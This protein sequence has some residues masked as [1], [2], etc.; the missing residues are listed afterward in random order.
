MWFRVI[1]IMLAVIRKRNSIKG[2]LGWGGWAGW[3]VSANRNRMRNCQVRSVHQGPSGCKYVQL[4]LGR[5]YKMRY[6]PATSSLDCHSWAVKPQRGAY[7]AGDADP[8]DAIHTRAARPNTLHLTIPMVAE[9]SLSGER[10]WPRRRRGQRSSLYGS[11]RRRLPI[12]H[13]P[14]PAV[15]AFCVDLRPIRARIVELLGQ[16]APERNYRSAIRGNDCEPAPDLGGPRLHTLQPLTSSPRF[17]VEPT[18]V[19]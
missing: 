16:R 3:N 5:P 1:E 8:G 7:D 12:D 15:S 10:L 2:S 14:R 6:R 11:R 19:L 17:L 4:V 13:R 9:M 18:P